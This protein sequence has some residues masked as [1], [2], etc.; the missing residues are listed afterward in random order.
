MWKDETSRPVEFRN[1]E[2]MIIPCVILISWLWAAS[3]L[4]TCLKWIEE[5]Y[6][7][8]CIIRL[9]KTLTSSLL[10]FS[11]WLFMH[12][13]SG[14]EGHLAR[15]QGQPLATDTFSPTAHEVL[16]P[17]SNHWVSSRADPVPFDIWND[18]GPGWHWLQFLRDLE[19][20]DSAKLCL[21]I[22]PRILIDYDCVLF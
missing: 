9:W 4:W 15:N 1:T 6:N 10:A 14:G 11:L 12:V 16:N 8:T 3:W 18:C 20:E 19:E 7:I 2:V 22:D 13:C 5:S 17:T 21:I